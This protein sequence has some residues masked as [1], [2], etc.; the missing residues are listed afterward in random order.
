MRYVKIDSRH[1][2][3]QKEAV[4]WAKKEK[5]DLKLADNKVKIETNYLEDGQWE[6]VV[7]L[8]IEE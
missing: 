4:K 3:L 1:F 8:K 7:F 5:S 2:R 6:A